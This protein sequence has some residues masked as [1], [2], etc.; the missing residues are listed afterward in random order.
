MFYSAICVVMK[1][2]Y[3]KLHKQSLMQTNPTFWQ[4][5][6]TLTANE[7]ESSTWVNK[8]EGFVSCFRL[9]LPVKN[10]FIWKIIF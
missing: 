3:A 7:K 8:Q 9:L 4:I 2:T 6:L 5:C 10:L 1:F